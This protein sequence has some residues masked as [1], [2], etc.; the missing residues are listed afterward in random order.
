MAENIYQAGTTVRLKGSFKDFSGSS[1]DP[2]VV[3]IVV[4]DQKYN[5][6]HTYDITDINKSSV[7]D[8]FY[9]F[10]TPFEVRPTKY[11]YEWYGEIL[12]SPSLKR[13]SFKTVFA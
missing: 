13:D 7:G 8:Y 2:S 10:H 1:I 3:R 11:Y 9:D 12:G 6:V 4:Y 5:I